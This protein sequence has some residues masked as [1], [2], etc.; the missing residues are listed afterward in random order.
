MEDHEVE[1]IS[2]STRKEKLINFIKNYLKI[3]IS[4]VITLILILFGYF[5][6]NDM[7]KK[8]ELKFQRIL[9]NP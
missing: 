1:I 2:S 8:K 3:I 5:F 9:T 6:Y 4:F 7:K